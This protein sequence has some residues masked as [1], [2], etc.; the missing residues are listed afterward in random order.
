ESTHFD[1]A[2]SALTQA[3]ADAGGYLESS[4]LGGS[5]E[6]QSRWA[7]YTAR[8]PAE[9]YRSFLL[10]AGEAASVLSQSEEAQDITST[11]VDV[12]ARLK[13]LENQRDRLNELAEKAE[14]TADLLEIESQLSDVQYQIESYTN[15]MRVMDDQVSYS[16][17]TISLSEV[18]VLTPMDDSFSSRIGRAFTDG[19]SDF[20]DSCEDFVVAV[21]YLLPVLLLAAVAF[22]AGAKLV[23]RRARRA[24]KRLSVGKEPSAPPEN[25]DDANT[26]KD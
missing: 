1:Q 9:Q 6:W 17:V 8:I 16:T 18:A 24:A 2:Q 10:A 20:A 19:W 13:T 23:R 14:T 4:N 5:A 12:E 11:Y 22:A 15:R 21:V 26:V 7:E 25:K 3:V